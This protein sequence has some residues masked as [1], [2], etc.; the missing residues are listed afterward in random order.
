MNYNYTL[1]LIFTGLNFR[2]FI[3]YRE[4][5]D[6]QKKVFA[7]IKHAKFNTYPALIL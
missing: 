1:L 7:K 2:D 6:P 4:R 5:K 3:D